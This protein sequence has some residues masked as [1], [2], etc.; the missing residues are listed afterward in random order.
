MAAGGRVEIPVVV[1][2]RAAHRPVVE[3]LSLQADAGPGLSAMA[4]IRLTPEPNEVVARTSWPIVPA[5][6][7]SAWTETISGNGVARLSAVGGELICEAEP[8]S[9]DRWFYPRLKLDGANRP[10]PGA[11]GVAFTFRLIEGSGTFRTLITETNGS[12][13]VIDWLTQPKR[14]IAVEAM[15]LFEDGTFGEGWSKPDPNHCFDP[16]QSAE[17]QIGCN[18]D[19]ARVKF[20][21]S[22]V[23]WIGF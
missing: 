12:T 1:N 2:D 18:C 3:K 10:P 13:Y 16:D 14:G 19:S 15:T 4:A 6:M 5:T 7:A 17:L 21:I 8:L 11:Q 22:N 23:R 20:A 9:H